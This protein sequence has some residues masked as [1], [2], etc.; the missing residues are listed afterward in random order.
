[1]FATT[2]GATALTPEW[3][4]ISTWLVPAVGFLAG[5]LCF[6]ASTG[7]GAWARGFLFAGVIF[8]LAAVVLIAAPDSLMKAGSDAVVD[9]A[10]EMGSAAKESSTGETAAQR[11]AEGAVVGTVVGLF[12]LM[13]IGLGVVFLVGLSMVLGGV[14]LILGLILALV[15]RRA[16]DTVETGV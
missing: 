14:H 4:G 8:S 13:G 15:S 9:A 2:I 3:S 5:A 16:G 1:M 11:A 6:T 12:G 10:T 7:V